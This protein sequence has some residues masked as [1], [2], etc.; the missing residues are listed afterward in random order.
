MQGTQTAFRL[1]PY[2]VK[3]QWFVLDTSLT[4]TAGTIV[5][6]HI[7]DQVSAFGLGEGISL[8]VATSLL[9]SDLLP[10]RILP[11]RDVLAHTSNEDIYLMPVFSK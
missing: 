2:A 6:M 7:A 11:P 8:L 5:L 1:L 3:R 10:C 9:Q 4:L